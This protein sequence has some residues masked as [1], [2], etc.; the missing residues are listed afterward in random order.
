MLKH[1]KLYFEL[2]CKRINYAK[3]NCKI[4]LLKYTFENDNLVA[5]IPLGKSIAEHLAE[6]CLAV[7]F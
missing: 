3:Y 1:C 7:F 2:W 6:I 4:N 5:N